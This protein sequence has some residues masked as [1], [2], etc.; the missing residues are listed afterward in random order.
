MKSISEIKSQYPEYAEMSNQEFGERLYKKYYKD[1]MDYD[2]FRVKS[3]SVEG[4]GFDV[5]NQDFGSVAKAINSIEDEKSRSKVRKLWADEWIRRSRK[6][7]EGVVQRVMDGITRFSNNIPVL[8]SLTD[9]AN[10]GTAAL[11]GEDYELM[12]DLNRAYNKQVSEASKNTAK[13]ADLPWIGEVTTG[14]IE[15]LGGVVAGSIVAPVAK[16]GSIVKDAAV[17]G[18]AYAG[19]EGFAQGEGTEDRLT[20][21]GTGIALGT[22]LGYGF[23]K[24]ATSDT[25]KAIAEKVG[26]AVSAV[27]KSASR[28]ATKTVAPKEIGDKRL[29]QALDDQGLTPEQAMTKLETMRQ[30]GKPV[31]LADLGTSLQREARGAKVASKEVD[32]IAEKQLL[33]RAESQIDRID[34]YARKAMKVDNRQFKGEFD[35][36]VEE[37]TK[38]AGP[39]YKQAFNE[40]QPVDVRPVLQEFMDIAESQRSPAAKKK[41]LE[42]IK[43]FTDE[44]KDSSGKVVKGP[45]GNPQLTVI[46]DLRSIDMA[47]KALDDMIGRSPSNPS[48]LDRSVRA[49]VIGFKNRMLELVDEANPTYKTARNVFSSKKSLEDSLTNGRRFLKGDAEFLAADIQK[50][51]QTERDM[52]RVGV[53]RELKKLMGTKRR[54]LDVTGMFTKPNTV[55]ALRATFPDDQAFL[56]FYENVADEIVMTM[57]KNKVLSGSQTTEKAADLMDLGMFRRLMQ[58]VKGGNIG[59]GIISTIAEVAEK[60]FRMAKADA[61]AVGKLL[62]EPSPQKQRAILNRLQ[63]RYGKSKIDKV[64]RVIG[65]SVARVYAENHLT[66]KAAMQAGIEMGGNIQEKQPETYQPEQSYNLD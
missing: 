65:R 1:K 8:G 47:K 49:E 5:E 42:A 51:S 3:G 50:M 38:Q 36:I 58:N 28:Q 57:T 40:A 54:G 30:G 22:A 19:L 2:T 29:M 18:G 15:K 34:D 63:E 4:L 53:V 41:M 23:G 7:N 31:T 20:G 16:T 37:R 26:D 60:T 52:F 66:S 62:L 10:A 27:T 17:T 55:D 25:V 14:D 59:G 61:D 33:A 32:A 35:R 21:A 64:R 48:S 11:F 46:Q 43:L 56:K 9:E 24:A 6:S 13:I 12:L 39:L 45:D 44:V